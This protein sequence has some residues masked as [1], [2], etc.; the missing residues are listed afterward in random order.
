MQPGSGMPPAESAPAQ[1]RPTVGDRVKVAMIVGD[2]R[3]RHCGVKDGAHQLAD[4]LGRIGFEV[5]VLAPNSWDPVSVVKFARLLRKEKYDILHVQ[6]PSIGYR[7]SLMPHVLGFLGISRAAIVTLHEFSGFTKLQQLSTHLFR[8]SAA[9]ILFVSEYEKSGFNRHLGLIGARQELFPVVSQVPAAPLSNERDMTVV[10]FGQIRPNK[11][12]EAYLQLAQRSIELRK[13]Y[14]F[15]ILGSIS[16]AHEEY[17]RSLQVQAP[18]ELRWSF[19]LPFEE[20]GEILGI[21]FAAY[22][23]FPDGASERRGSL[24]AALLNGLPVLSRIGAATPPAIRELV[25]SVNNTEEALSALDELSSR[26]DEYTRISRA[27]REY[28]REHTWEDVARQHAGFYRALF[29]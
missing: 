14:G 26:P 13:P 24:V 22:L 5:N 23:P 9:T 8:C 25:L 28:G 19:D 3:T 15:H 16:S 1:S 6:Y 7:A 10:Y 20:I 4:A 29:S 18:P 17:A 11:G 12:L 27:S 2:N 21:S